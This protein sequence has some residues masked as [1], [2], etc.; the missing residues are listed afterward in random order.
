MEK[1]DFFYIRPEDVTGD[2]LVLAKGETHHLKNVFRKKIGD[3]FSA[4]DGMGNAFDCQIVILEKDT[5][6]ARILKRTQ[7][8]GEPSFQL[9]T[10]LAIP[11][12]SRFEWLVEKGT[13]IG[14]SKFIPLLTERTVVKAKSINMTRCKRIALS[15]MKQSWRCVLPEIE[16]PLDFVRLC[17]NADIYN[18]K[19]V[20]H[21]KSPVTTFDDILGRRQTQNLQQ[22]KTGLLCVGP[23]GGFSDDEVRLARDCGFTMVGLGKRR[24]RSETASLIGSALIL[25]RVGEFR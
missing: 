23:E 17:K 24:L 1:S 9:T 5:C 16:E 12:K 18:I 8:V 3:R 4:V 15:A 2:F 11:K 19:L 6:R 25:D 14:I 22:L 7:F 10:A 20:A 21:E 13:E